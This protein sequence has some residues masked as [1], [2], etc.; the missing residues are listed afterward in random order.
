MVRVKV[1]EAISQGHFQ[2]GEG[3]CGR[4]EGRM[5]GGESVAQPS[6]IFCPSLS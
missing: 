3:A 4:A 2:L 1:Q 6:F 5:F